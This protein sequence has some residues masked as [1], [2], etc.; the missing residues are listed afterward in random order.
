MS[1]WRFP[2]NDG[3]EREGINSSYAAKFRSYRIPSLAREICQNS[4][5]AKNKELDASIPVVLEFESFT[6]SSKEIPQYEKYK[7]YLTECYEYWVEKGQPNEIAAFKE[8]LDCINKK[9]IPFLRISDHNTTGVRRNNHSEWENLIRS[10]GS[11]NKE[12]GA[13]GSYGLGKNAP[14][15][16]SILRTILYSTYT[17]EEEHL[18]QG[19][20]RFATFEDKEGNE[21]RSVGYYCEGKNA[22]V[23]GELVLDKNYKREENDYGTDIYIAGFSE[24]SDDEDWA[25]KLLASVIDNFLFAIYKGELEI[26][27]GGHILNKSTI[28]D[29]VDKYKDKLDCQDLYYNILTKQEPDVH[30]KKI[31]FQGMG[32]VDIWIIENDPNC[33]HKIKMIRKNGM[34]IQEWDRFKNAPF[35]GI[36][37]ISG[38]VINERL[39]ELE[40]PEH[41]D[42]MVDNLLDN[43]AR[44]EAKKLLDSLRKEIKAFV[45][46]IFNTTNV[47]EMDVA[48]LGSILPDEDD[49]ENTT[50]NNGDEISSE[51]KVPD[52]TDTID[53]MV[54]EDPHI[55]PL[56]NDD[57]RLDDDNTDIPAADNGDDAGDDNE[58]DEEDWSESSESDPESESE[59]SPEP[60]IPLFDDVDTEEKGD[61]TANHKI[62]VNLSSL[63]SICLD[64]QNGKYRLLVVPSRDAADC[65]MEIYLSAE[66]EIYPVEIISASIGDEILPVKNNIIGKMKFVQ[67]EKKIIDAVLDTDIYCSIE[68]KAYEKA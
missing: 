21:Y 4:L 39:R 3:G 25:I 28:G 67:G 16:C 55:A 30:H 60:E 24:L 7:E 62:L 27:A 5:D 2:Q 43:K 54:D 41:T 59:P 63:R 36:C 11:S 34:S 32:D 20:A 57:T 58:Q 48:G 6:I 51:E 65:E 29:F 8:S 31:N 10:T 35:A 64:P 12:A 68:V 9:K 38:E 42:W 13:G 49:D 56:G 66:T 1:N 47:S 44:R 17:L 53:I 26:R 22:P 46:E 37:W 40:N 52:S 50:I 14:F 23:D 61:N 19:V 15:A 18:H 45:D 33:H